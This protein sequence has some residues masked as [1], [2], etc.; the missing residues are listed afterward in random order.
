VIEFLHESC[1]FSTF[2][3]IMIEFIH[4]SLVASVLCK[5]HIEW[6]VSFLDLLGKCTKILCPYYMV[7]LNSAYY[8]NRYL[9]ARRNAWALC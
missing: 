4:M 1:G 9:N 2:G 3:M 8:I 7:L 5:V 6:L